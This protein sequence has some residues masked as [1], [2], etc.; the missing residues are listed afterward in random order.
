MI[1]SE[2]CP[3]STTP[4]MTKHTAYGICME[5]LSHKTNVQPPVEFLCQRFHFLPSAFVAASDVL[6]CLPRMCATEKNGGLGKNGA[7]QIMANVYEL[8]N[9]SAPFTDVDELFAKRF[10]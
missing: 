2:T 6:R 1:L 7:K 4:V 5:N 8:K 3:V 9:S 10:G